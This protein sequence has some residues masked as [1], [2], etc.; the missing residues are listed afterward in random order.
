MAVPHHVG[1]VAG[2]ALAGLQS[3]RPCHVE[4]KLL[5]RLLQLHM[6]LPLHIPQ[7]QPDSQ[8]VTGRG[9][10]YNLWVL[11]G[12]ARRSPVCAHCKRPRRSGCGRTSSHR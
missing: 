10:W 7:L 1:G 8:H 5:A 3:V 9:A 2:A 6:G 11:Q 4:E 12:P